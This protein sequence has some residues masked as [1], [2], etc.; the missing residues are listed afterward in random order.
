ME[1]WSLQ[2]R[3]CQTYLTL[4]PALIVVKLFS[5][6]GHV[7]PVQFTFGTLYVPRVGAA[8]RSANSAK[9]RTSLNIKKTIFRVLRLLQLFK[10]PEASDGLRI[11]SILPARVRPPVEAEVDAV[12]EE[13][14]VPARLE[15]LVTGPAVVEDGG[16]V[17]MAAADVAGAAAVFVSTLDADV[18]IWVKNGD[19]FNLL[20]VSLCKP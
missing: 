11:V 12:V 8:N 2:E 13:A 14:A 15:V 18:L 10:Y 16:G 5:A 9:V 4:S 3:T 19:D 6:A 20:L 7:E 1:D 17:G